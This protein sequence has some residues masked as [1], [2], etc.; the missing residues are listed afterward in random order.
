MTGGEARSGP[1]RRHRR[2]EKLAFQLQ[3]N[4]YLGGVD[5]FGMFPMFLLTS[6]LRG[7][8]IEKT[9]I[10]IINSAVGTGP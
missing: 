8:E 2:F 4:R 7:R 6:I 10:I 3:R 9:I 5:V 1:S